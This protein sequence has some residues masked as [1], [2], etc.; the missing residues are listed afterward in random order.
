MS[1][2]HKSPS[3]HPAD[4]LPA[5][6]RSR[7]LP[8]TKVEDIRQRVLRGDYPVGSAEL[9]RVLVREQVLTEYQA[10]RLLSNKLGGLMIG[11]YVIMDRLGSGSMGRVYKAKH[12]MMD[13]VVALKIIA[14]EIGSNERVVAR[15]QREMK[16][17]GKL[18]HPNVVR[19]YDAD[20]D[21]GI[22]FIAMEHVPGE[23]L[24]A[25]LKT[26]G[27]IPAAE[28]VEYAAQAALGLQHAHDQNIVHRDVKPSNLLVNTDG[29]VKV[30]D[31]GL[32]V[33]LEADDSA[34]F[35]TAEGIA[36]GTI[37]YMSPEQACGKDV[38]NRSDLFS[39]GCTMY[40]LLCGKL[41]FPGQSPV[42]R[43]GAR[44]NGSPVPIQDVKPDIPNRLV[45]VLDTLMANRPSD[46]YQTAAEASDALRALLGRPAS[47]KAK[48]AK[49][50]P[51][52]APAP[53]Q[54]KYVEVKPKYPGWFQPWARRAE[55]S[56]ESILAIVFT[57]ALV[58]GGLC[59]AAGWLVS[60]LV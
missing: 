44:I 53:P 12:Q 10:K 11:R 24:G 5:L 54:I 58:W 17:V 50:E 8:D 48:P 2:A 6:K 60:T 37:D 31:L 21:Q 38:D 45:Q 59:F 43:L 55:S 32:G 3:E 7:I 33:L 36:V 15:F 16:L 46:R 22:L 57:A 9:A 26:R 47:A 25:R 14:P 20:K 52:P 13:R 28:L 49:A 29:V 19:A 1:E 42:E 23:S 56:P 40:H 4:L 34:S 51:A 18:D 27:P 39:L 30:L 35:A 41:P